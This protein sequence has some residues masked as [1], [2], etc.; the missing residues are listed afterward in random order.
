MIVLDVDNFLLPTNNGLLNMSF[1]KRH[2]LKKEVK[3]RLQLEFRK[4]PK[5][6]RDTLPYKR[7]RVTF[8][9]RGANRMDPDNLNASIKPAL[10]ALRPLKVRSGIHKTGKKKGQ[11]W[12]KEEGL[13][14]VIAGDSTQEIELVCR[15]E[16]ATKPGFRLIIEPLED[17]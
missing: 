4:L 16:K 15:W 6:I 3:L 11:P 17:E 14:G 12:T 10:D 5:A 2:A 9:R 13:L 1:W 8:I 7:A